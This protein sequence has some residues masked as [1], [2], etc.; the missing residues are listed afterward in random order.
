MFEKIKEY[1]AVKFLIKAV[2][3]VIAVGF[4]PLVVLFVGMGKE[5]DW[6][7]MPEHHLHNS[8][9]VTVEQELHVLGSREGS[10][11]LRESATRQIG[12][13]IKA[14]ASEQIAAAYGLDLND[15]AQM[16]SVSDFLDAELAKLPVSMIQEQDI[17]TSDI[18]MKRYG[19]Y[20]I[21]KAELDVW[22]QGVYLSY[23][24]KVLEE[25]GL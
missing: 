13:F 3:F 24:R 6:I 11:E 1:L 23:N 22:L 17:Y 5:P 16:R 15:D 2:M 4:L 20:S 10:T 9:G 7:A 21:D 12:A 18:S 14:K 8:Y 25:M 19:L